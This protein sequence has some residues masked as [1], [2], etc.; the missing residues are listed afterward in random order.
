MRMNQDL[1]HRLAAAE[2]RGKAAVQQRT[3]LEALARARL[4]EVGSL[5]QEMSRL[6]AQRHRRVPGPET[7][8]ET[9]TETEA[10]VAAGKEV[11]MAHASTQTTVSSGERDLVV[12]V[13]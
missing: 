11:F 10:E 3:E 8:M 12:F 6:K 4:Q 9:E 1:R 2:S 5:Q 7:E 13:C